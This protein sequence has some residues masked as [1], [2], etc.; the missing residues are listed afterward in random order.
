MIHGVTVSLNETER[1]FPSR[2]AD[3]EWGTEENGFNHA[4]MGS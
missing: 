3:K 2:Q 4:T 1:E